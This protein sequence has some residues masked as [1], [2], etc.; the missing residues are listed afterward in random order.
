M[1]SRWKKTYFRIALRSFL[2][3]NL[4]IFREKTKTEKKE[5]KRDSACDENLNSQYAR[6]MLLARNDVFYFREVTSIYRPVSRKTKEIYIEYLSEVFQ[7]IEQRRSFLQLFF[8]YVLATGTILTILML[9][10]VLTLLTTFTP[11]SVISP[12]EVNIY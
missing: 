9:L 7:S 8:Y 5:K 11:S 4:T 3:R 2:Y 10:T 6:R 12:L 1:A